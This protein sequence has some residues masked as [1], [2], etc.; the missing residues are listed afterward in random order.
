MAKEQIHRGVELGVQ[1][2]KK[3]HE[4]VSHEGHCEDAQDQREKEDVCGSIIKDS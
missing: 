4:S 2:D 1:V 3:N